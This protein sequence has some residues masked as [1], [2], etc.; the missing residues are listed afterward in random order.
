ME[1]AEDALCAEI[2]LAG[3]KRRKFEIKVNLKFVLCRQATFGGLCHNEL[4]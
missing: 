4:Q 1:R 2:F 3:E